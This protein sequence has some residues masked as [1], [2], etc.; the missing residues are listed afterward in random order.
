ML[1]ATIV[2]YLYLL[3]A[4][5]VPML[6]ISASPASP[7]VTTPEPTLLHDI[8]AAE[9]APTASPVSGPNRLNLASISLEGG[10]IFEGA[11][12]D[13][14]KKGIWHRPLSS[15]PDKGGN[16]VLAAHRFQYLTGNNTFYKLDKV[17]VGDPVSLIWDGRQ[18]EYIVTSSSIVTDR[19]VEIENPSLDPIL[20]LYT[21][22]P[23]WTSQNRLVVVAKLNP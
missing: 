1:Y 6:G 3:A 14:L 11:G 23:L 15:T 9:T 19:S 13:T 16:T 12:E 8:A 4:P 22:T 2:L 7:S 10:E 17:K 21:C 18:Y 5:F 20:T